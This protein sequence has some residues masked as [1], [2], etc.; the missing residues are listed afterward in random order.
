LDYHGQRYGWGPAPA[1]QYVLSYARD[2]ALKDVDQPLLLFY[3]TQNSHYPWDPLPELVDDWRTL[4][5][6]TGAED[7]LPR[8]GLE[9]QEVRQNYLNAIEYEIDMLVNFI[10]DHADE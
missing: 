4:G 3:I 2:E 9:H 6:D 10:L 5:A 7:V 8:E 1:D